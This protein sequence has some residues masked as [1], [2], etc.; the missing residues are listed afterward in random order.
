MPFPCPHCR[1]SIWVVAEQPPATAQQLAAYGGKYI[2]HLFRSDRGD[3]WGV[4]A[5]AKVQPREFLLTDT[6]LIECKR[7]LKHAK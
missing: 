3:G 5:C 7:C 6:N 4:S 1:K 2:R